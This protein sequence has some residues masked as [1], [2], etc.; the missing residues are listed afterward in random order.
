VIRT[1]T[2]DFGDQYTSQLILH[3]SPYFSF[4][5]FS[6]FFAFVYL[7]Y[8]TKVYNKKLT[9]NNKKPF[10][11]NFLNFPIQP[12][13]PF[14]PIS[15]KGSINL[16]LHLRKGVGWAGKVKDLTFIPPTYTE[17]RV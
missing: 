8:Q 7:P 13:F 2:S 10:G 4:K 14:T 9:K 3:S 16:Y 1:P 6:L 17:G 11:Y 15:G 5:G 12:D